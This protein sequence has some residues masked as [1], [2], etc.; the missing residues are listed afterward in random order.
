TVL[1]LRGGKGTG[2]NT[3][4]DAVVEMFGQ[5]GIAIS[6]QAHLVGHF[7]AHLHGRA[8]L[9]ANEA[10]PPGD[11]AAESRL[12]ALITD[13]VLVIERK[14][15]N[16][17]PEVNALS[18]AMA[19]NEAW[20]VPATGDERRYCVIDV[21][22]HAVGRV[23]YWSALHAEMSNGGKAAMLHD[24]LA[25]E[26][27]DWHPR[28]DVPATIALGEQKLASLRGADR[29]VRDLLQAGEA[30]DG[31]QQPAPPAGRE[32]GLFVATQIW[33]STLRYRGEMRVLRQ[34][35]EA[36]GGEARRARIGPQSLRGYWLPPLAEAR[37]RWSDETGIDCAWATD[38]GWLSD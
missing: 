28:R 31:Y 38:G 30:P 36:A 3:L 20:C 22:K 25:L 17:E 6:N 11:K 34:A 27:G 2:K 24:M 13:P 9:F 37:A 12:K 29:H 16:A 15:I 4:L 23:S 19:T 1:V 21:A 26:L 33:A 35:L 18:I 8:F 32:G 5:H 14:G 10:V 7:N